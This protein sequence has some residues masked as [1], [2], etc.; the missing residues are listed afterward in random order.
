MKMNIPD[1]SKAK[2]LVIGDLM[3]DSYYSGPASRI[4]PE[5]PVPIVRVQKKESRPGGAANVALNIASLG[6]SCTLVGYVGIDREGSELTSML[7]EKG[8]F[9]R[10]IQIQNYPTITKTRVLSRHQQLIRLDFEQNFTDVDPA[11]LMTVI[12]D[13]INEFQVIILSDYGKGVL[14][15]AAEIVKMARSLGKIVLIDPKGTDFERYEGATVITPNL[16]E[17]EAV[18]GTV[19]SEEDLA[20]R[21]RAM[22]SKYHLSNL[23]VTRSEKGM[24]L[25]SSDE[26]DFHLP[27]NAREV[28][29]VTGAGDTVI[30]V[31]AASLATGRSFRESCALSNVA[32][33]IV[34]GKLGTS[35]VSVSELEAELG[36]SRGV[37]T[38]VVSETELRTLVAGAK[39]RGE[40][41]VMTNGCFDILHSGH[42][43]YLKQARELGD[44][45][46]VAV[47]SDQ[48][49]RGLKGDS[50]PVNALKD[51]M[52]VLA[53][54]GSVDW[55]VPFD[56]D[57][58]RR[59]ISEI[60][61]DI[62]VK[63]GDYKV[64]EIAGAKEVMANGGR[65]EI[66]SF[67]D[68]CSTTG[69]I[70]RIRNSQN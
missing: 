70:N 9:C 36:D 67:K 2:V 44:R 15:H 56:E 46:I 19:Q 59:L 57:T 51:R 21:A 17:F 7:V 43:Q 11:G 62:L 31:L 1:Y 58:P 26:D 68:G 65:V 54:L 38:G 20:F 33:G 39:A 60:L 3:L 24:S 25:F 32:A 40:V 27:T 63:G 12:R 53:A 4:S 47:N 48:S 5:A 61:P 30:A 69:I 23:L 42:C 6:G 41:V 16:S 52:D 28:Y 22:M 66:L 14:K 35:T 50:R 37:E 55:V 49:V 13:C 18:A 64:D 45:L 34:V 8:V 29:D 10:F